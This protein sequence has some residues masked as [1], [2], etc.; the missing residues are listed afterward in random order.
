MITDL[1]PHR[2]WLSAQVDAYVCGTQESAQAAV[3]RGVAPGRLHALGIPITPPV[4]ATVSRRELAGRFGLEPHRQTVLVTSG[5][6]T[7]GPFESVVDAL[8]ALEAATPGRLQLLVVC[9]EDGSALKRLRARGASSPMP[10]RVFGFTEEMPD[11]MAASD[12]IVA[13][14]GGMIISEALGHGLPIILYHVIPGQEQRNARYVA[15]HGAAVIALRPR[16]VA[17]AAHHL[18]EHPEEMAK[19]R[20][21]ASALRRP[22]AAAAIASEVVRP[23]LQ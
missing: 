1:H 7:V 17:S 22:D 13:K 3:L 8:L 10:M 6:T 14:A 11:L 4:G 15:T 5:G 12:L 9:G 19:M 16:T 18:L 21:A 20:Q 2:F 23:L